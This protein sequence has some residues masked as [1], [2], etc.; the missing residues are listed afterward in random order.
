MDSYFDGIVLVR[1]LFERSLAA[2]YL[3]AFISALNQFKPLLGEKGLLPAPDFI[4]QTSFRNT[5]TIFQ[6]HYSDNFFTVV[7]LSGTILSAS[8]MIGLFDQLPWYGYI[9]GW[10]LIWFLYMSIVNVGQTFYSFGWES[11]ILEAGFFAAFLGPSY[12]TP[13]VIPILLLR[14]MLF[15][16]EFGAGMIKIRHDQCWRD[17]T[18]L[19]YHYETQPMPGPLSWHFHHMPKFVHRFGVAFSHFVQLV[20]PFGVFAPQPV[21]QIAAILI[22]GHQLWLVFCG[23]YSWLN[24]LTI[25]LGFTVLSDSMLSHVFTLPTVLVDRPLSY[26]IV[27]YVLLVAS[28]ILSWKPLLNFFS[29]D[30][31]MNYCFNPYHL[32]CVYGAF[33]SVT[34]ERYELIVEATDDSTLNANTVWKEYE[35]KGKPGDLKK[36]PRQ[37]AP[38]HLRLDWAMWFL[39]FSVVVR[40]NKV[41]YVSTRTWFIQFLEGLLKSDKNILGLL[42]KVPFEN[43]RPSFVRVMYYRYQFTTPDEKKQTGNIWKRELTGEY[44]APTSLSDIKSF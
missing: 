44:I 29:K 2:I 36:V 26:D 13:S 21:A 20:V 17:Y 6:F 9:L 30:Q 31:M 40:N 10:L 22:I 32:V 3:I 4:K 27:L 42:Q 1:L 43:T 39:P 25:V 34:K 18:C 5:P 23:N 37:Y 16:V 24:W 11:M 38:Y 7:T 33:G 15:R 12:M 19:Y 8:I 35:F 28:L 14:W 41:L